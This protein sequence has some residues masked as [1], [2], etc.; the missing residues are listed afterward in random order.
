MLPLVGLMDT[1]RAQRMMEVLL[2][3]IEETGARV[4]LLDVTGLPVLDTS[5]ARHL[6]D[7]VSGAEL[8]GTQAIITGI[9][10]ETAQTLVK[11]NVRLD[12][13]RTTGDLQ[14]GLRRAIA[15]AGR[16]TMTSRNRSGKRRQ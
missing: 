9:R 3:A 13:I 8:L 1:V 11:L 2:K 12:A 10:P 15:L 4:A 6:L 14:G 7:T 16:Q 5:V